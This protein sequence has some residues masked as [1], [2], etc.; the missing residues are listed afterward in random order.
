MGGGVDPASRPRYSFEGGLCLAR[1]ARENSSV[2]TATSRC[3]VTSQKFQ[4][5]GILSSIW[6]N[7][8]TVMI[9]G[10]YICFVA[11]LASRGARNSFN[12]AHFLIQ[13]EKE[14][15]FIL[16]GGTLGCLE[17]SLARS[18]SK[19]PNLLLNEEDRDIS[20]RNGNKL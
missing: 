4:G 19:G 17:P 16:W 10:S 6:E 14:Q 9:N 18:P 8:G 2:R 20:I 1:V 13:Q 11:L 12:F 5:H 3:G 7:F 15:D